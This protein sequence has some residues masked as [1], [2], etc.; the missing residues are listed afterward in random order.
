MPWLERKGPYRSLARWPPR[1]C[2]LAPGCSLVSTTPRPA[3]LPR[4]LNCTISAVRWHAL[5]VHHLQG[6]TG[7]ACSGMQKHSLARLCLPTLV[8]GVP[9][10]RL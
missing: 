1:A 6:A 3:L 4:L 2:F 5:L 7:R 8:S 9:P 10:T